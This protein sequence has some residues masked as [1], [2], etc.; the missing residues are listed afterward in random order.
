MRA[1]TV[2]GA[3]ASYAA[4]PRCSWR[5]QRVGRPRLYEAPRASRSIVYRA[6][7]AVLDGRTAVRAARSRRVYGASLY[8]YRTSVVGATLEPPR[9]PTSDVDATNLYATEHRLSD[10]CI[11][12][13]PRE[14]RLD[15]IIN[16]LRLNIKDYNWALP[17]RRAQ[18]VR[19]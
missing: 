1:A 13:S 12:G 3:P 11:A 5:R 14:R 6:T 18:R 19:A 2:G 4:L 9:C 16:L 7:A 10:R 17:A 8:A 15:P